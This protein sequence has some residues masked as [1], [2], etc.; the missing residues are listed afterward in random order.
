MV[1][2]VLLVEYF[3]KKKFRLGSKFVADKVIVFWVHELFELFKNIETLP[4]IKAL[5]TLFK[6]LKLE[7][8]MQ[9]LVKARYPINVDIQDGFQCLL[10]FSKFVHRSKV[11]RVSF[12]YVILLCQN[13]SIP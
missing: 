12:C 11:N 4:R 6:T 7:K 13:F 9:E 5:L 3:F 1:V 2:N 10:T 8:Q